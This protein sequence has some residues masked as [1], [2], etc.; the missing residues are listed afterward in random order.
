MAK[1][2]LNQALH[3]DQRALADME[4]MA[5]ALCLAGLY[6]GSG[7]NASWTKTP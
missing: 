7:S 4:T 3:T 5:Q 2:I 1:T 6:K